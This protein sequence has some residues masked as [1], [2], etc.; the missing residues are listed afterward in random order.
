[1]VLD[2]RRRARHWFGAGKVDQP[3][4]AALGVFRSSTLCIIAPSI[5][6]HWL[7][8]QGM[9]QILRDVNSTRWRP[10]AAHCKKYCSCPRGMSATSL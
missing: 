2:G 4:E 5:G 8:W 1:M 10:R 3:S 6:Q 9:Q 7:F